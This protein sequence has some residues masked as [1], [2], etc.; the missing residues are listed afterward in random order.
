[1]NHAPLQGAFLGE[2][3][4]GIR[5]AGFDEMHEMTAKGTLLWQ[6]ASR[7]YGEEYPA[8][9]QPTGMTTWWILGRC[10]SALR[11]G[12]GQLFVDLAC[13][14]GGPGLWLARAT[15]ANLIGIDWSHVAIEDAR[16]RAPTFVPDGRAQFAVGDLAESGL[17]AGEADAVLCLDALFFAKDRVAALSEAWRLLQAGGRYV[18]TGTETDAPEDQSRVTDWRPLLDAAGLEIES[19]EQVPHYADRLQRMYDLWIENLGAIRAELG[20][21]TAAELEREAL[22]VGPT[23]RQ[24]RQLVIVARPTASS[25]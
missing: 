24:R 20:D 16:R 9:V 1:M 21:E 11:V 22:T 6:L 13:G 14:R 25:D 4:D 17:P 10:V 3:A 15:G 7:A 2:R 23:L 12:P 19:K 5:A 8:E 18:F